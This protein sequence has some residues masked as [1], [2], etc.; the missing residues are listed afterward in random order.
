MSIVAK[1]ATLEMFPQVF[2]LLRQF[3]VNNPDITRE[4]W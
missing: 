2:G 3:H 1:E 4:H